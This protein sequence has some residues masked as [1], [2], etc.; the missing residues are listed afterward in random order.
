MVYDTIDVDPYESRVDL[1]G[2]EIEC[3]ECG[4]WAVASDWKVFDTSCESCGGHPVLMCPN[5]DCKEVYDPYGGS[6]EELNV[7]ETTDS[8]DTEP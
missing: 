8:P 6:R 4:K 7:R 2:K 5:E 1:P 3:P